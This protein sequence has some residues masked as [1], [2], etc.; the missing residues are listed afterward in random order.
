MKDTLF[1][2]A[3]LKVLQDLMQF[4]LL[5][6]PRLPAYY[7]PHA[8]DNILL[9]RTCPSSLLTCAVTYDGIINGDD[10]HLL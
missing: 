9:L 6:A 1:P 10:T 4:S 2:A 7:S 5:A 3:P 8:I